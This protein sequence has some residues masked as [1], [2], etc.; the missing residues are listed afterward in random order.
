[1]PLPYIVTVV[2]E[3]KP[4]KDIRF[5]E[6][7]EGK[8]MSESCKVKIRTTPKH[9]AVAVK[10]KVIFKIPSKDQGYLRMLIGGREESSFTHDFG[11]IEKESKN[12]YSFE[13]LFISDYSIENLKTALGGVIFL[14]INTFDYEDNLTSTG[15]W[16]TPPPQ[17]DII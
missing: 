17:W 16:P 3:K 13:F 7:A 2:T 12:E 8:L 1:M 5:K 6:N 9:Y 4:T 15:P 14:K 11:K 10:C